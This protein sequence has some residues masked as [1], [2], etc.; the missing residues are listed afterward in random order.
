MAWGDDGWSR[1]VNTP[2]AANRLATQFHKWLRKTMA[3]A[4]EVSK[5]DERQNQTR[6]G[7]AKPDESRMSRGQRFQDSAK[8]ESLPLGPTRATAQTH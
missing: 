1:Q 2:D 7:K 5:A 3:G 8:R 6:G 4:D